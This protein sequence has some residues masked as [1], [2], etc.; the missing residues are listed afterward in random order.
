MRRVLGE[1]LTN[2]PQYPEVVGDT[3]IL[4][5]LRGHNY[6]IEKVPLL[7]SDNVVSA[8]LY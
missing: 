4:R 7:R 6:D 5:F 3:R 8:Q 1:Q 2:R